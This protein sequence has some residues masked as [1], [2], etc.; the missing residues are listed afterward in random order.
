[1]KL[2]SLQLEQF[3]KFSQG[4]GIAD[5]A[6][7]LNLIAGPN[8]M[9]K[10]TLLLALRAALFERHGSKSQAIKALQPNHI[11][12]AAPTVT[13]ELET[14]DG[15]YRIEKRFLRR[16]KARLTRPDGQVA[17]GQDAEIAI[18]ALLGLDDDAALALDKGS[19]SH[20]GIM[21]TPQ[22]QSF[23]QPIVTTGTRHTLEE[24]ITAEIEQLGNQSEVDAIL[25]NVEMEA[26]ALVDKRGKPKGRHKDISTRLEDLEREI[27]A[28][29]HDRVALADDFQAL[30]RAKTELQSLE[31]GDTLD[32]LKQAL[33]DLET[34]RGELVRRQEIEGRL[35]ALRYRVDHLTQARDRFERLKMEQSKLD[36]EQ[37]E[38]VQEANDVETQLKASETDLAHLQ[39]ERQSLVETDETNQQK[40]Q[41]FEQLRRQLGQRAQINDA[42]LA[43]ATEVTI[44]LEPEAIDHVRLNDQSME[45]TQE[46]VQAIEGLTIDILNI[47]QVK[48]LPKHDKLDDLR[49]HRSVLDRAIND[50]L[51]TLGL[52][53][54][55]PDL[56]EEAWR[57]IEEETEQLLSRR[58]DLDEILNNLERAVQEQKAAYQQRVTKRQQIAARLSTIAD[59]IKSD[60]AFKT[61]GDAFDKT[62]L[63]AEAELATVQKD[64]KAFALTEEPV[65]PALDQL[66]ADIKKLR[67]QIDERAQKIND[68]KLLIGRLSA[69]IAVRSERG[70]DERLEDCFRRREILNLELE[71]YQLDT[72]ALALLKGT[73][74]DAANDAKAKFQAP[75]AARLTPYVRALLPDATPEVTADFEISALNRNQP[76]SEKF[77]QLSDGTREQ[78]AV[79]TRLAYAQ[80]LKEEGRPALLVLD[81]ALVFSDEQRLRRMFTILEKAAETMQIII[82]TCR[83]DRFVSLNAK[84][85]QI[86]QL[87]DAA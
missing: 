25:A 57:E 46:I 76:T 58:T 7:G 48:I 79:L 62:L 35:T 47:G 78:I 49:D 69:T 29:E 18:Q 52:E 26:Y 81:D 50:H 12:G 3:K 45:Q 83:D 63:D 61:M 44:D 23:H 24:A 2:R 41:A 5:F 74:I 33:H 71:R 9:G 56:I 70:L 1:M 28:L 66:E 6:D 14:D 59:D 32:D 67:Q 84:R 53:N 13:V 77:E 30:D 16:A 22:S 36:A 82:M 19:P 72:K 75:L 65:A 54:A 73:L 8:E 4:V 43:I 39:G 55:E 51:E 10:S 80:M 64:A 86:E 31:N 87:A 68:A 37:K 27:E 15:L 20:F 17:E 60:E 42:L 40:R 38:V 34:K 85:L 11:Q 21:L